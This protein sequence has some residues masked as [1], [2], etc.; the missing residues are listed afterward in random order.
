MP[1]KGSTAYFFLFQT[2][3]DVLKVESVLKSQGVRFELVPVPR[4]LSSDC[5]VCVSMQTLTN[6]V[7]LLL[8]SLNVDRCFFF[9]GK[10]YTCIDLNGPDPVRDRQHGQMEEP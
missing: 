10:E 7:A 4:T 6:G 2:I 3:H 9:N 8:S 1:G 5:G